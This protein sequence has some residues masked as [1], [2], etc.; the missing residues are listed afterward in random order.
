MG[1]WNGAGVR[2]SRGVWGAG[3][4]ESSS[5]WGAGMVQV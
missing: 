2:E 5:E 3:V 4:R 1:C